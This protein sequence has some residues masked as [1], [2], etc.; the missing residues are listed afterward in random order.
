MLSG[1]ASCESFC[2]NLRFAL[3][4]NARQTIR[5]L[6]FERN[7]H[8]R[9]TIAKVV[10]FPEPATASTS[11]TFEEQAITVACSGVGIF[12]ILVQV[13]FAPA[14]TNSD[15]VCICHG[16]VEKMEMRIG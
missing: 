13:W 12:G 16:T 3:S 8:S 11:C 14:L 9:A 4:V 15:S 7:V 5:A 10:V 2:L 1:D 6:E